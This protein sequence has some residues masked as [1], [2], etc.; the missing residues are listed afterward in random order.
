MLNSRVSGDERGVRAFIFESVGPGTYRTIERSSV[1]DNGPRRA[2][3]EERRF[4]GW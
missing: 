2:T 3:V 4:C 1:P